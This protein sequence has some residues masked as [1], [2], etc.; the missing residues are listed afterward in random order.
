MTGSLVLDAYPTAAAYLAELPDGLGS[1]P[2]CLAY[3]VHEGAR[4]QVLEHGGGS[5]DAPVAQ[6][7]AASWSDRWIPD[8]HGLLA[9][10]MLVDVLGE[11]AY[12]RWIYDEARRIYD[13]PFLRHMMR[14]LSP[15]LVLMGGASR[16]GA[17]HRGSRL[18][19]QSSV[20]AEHRVTSGIVLEYPHG[21]FSPAFCRGLGETFRAAFDLAHAANTTVEVVEHRGQHS[22]FAV[23]WDR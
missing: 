3:E 18:A 23:G 21:L 17:V 13:R 8:V 2:E 1:H 22:R 9:Q 5:I 12:L 6:V 20:K 11:A 19:A 10:M 7:L 4:R 15:S 16:W 14:L